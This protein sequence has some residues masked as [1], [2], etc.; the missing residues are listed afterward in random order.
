MTSPG[1]SLGRSVKNFSIISCSGVAVFLDD[2]NESMITENQRG[3]QA[4]R[5][6]WCAVIEEQLGLV[7]NPSSKDRGF[8]R[9]A[10][11][12]WFGSYDFAMV[13]NLAGV[14]PDYIYAGFTARLLSETGGA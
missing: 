10:A 14:D 8:Q 3:A 11:R 13:C 9:D 1:F 5:R 4:C 6:L 2:H 12:R 7:F